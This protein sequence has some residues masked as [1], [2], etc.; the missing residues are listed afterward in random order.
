MSQALPLHHPDAPSLEA[1]VSAYARAVLAHEEASEADQPKALTCL[2]AAARAVADRVLMI[3]PDCARM[4]V[5]QPLDAAN[6]C[7]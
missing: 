7:V 6:H 2:N 3:S 4:R 1:L 5:S